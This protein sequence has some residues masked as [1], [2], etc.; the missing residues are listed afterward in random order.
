MSRPKR[1]TPPPLSKTERQAL[2]DLIRRGARALNPAEGNRLLRLLEH[3]Q[4]DR[5]Q[6]R[7]TAGVADAHNQ[8][9]TAQLKIAT[10][11][12]ELAEAQLA[13]LHEGEE[14][15]EDE[16]TA[17]TPAQWIWRWNRATAQERMEAA[18]LMIDRGERLWAVKLLTWRWMD[19]PGMH[20]AAEQLH[21]TLN[22]AA[23]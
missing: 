18:A 22:G 5:Q 10:A 9:L 7:R 15:Y 8:K 20:Q 17:P 1:P 3:D 4:A 13:A 16:N 21:E 11:R 23:E 12:A 14:P 19:V 6:E 2:D